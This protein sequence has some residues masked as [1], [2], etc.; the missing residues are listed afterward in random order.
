MGHMKRQRKNIRPT[1]RE[2]NGKKAATELNSK[3]TAAD[4]H[5]QMEHDDSPI[6]YLVT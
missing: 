4:M 1:K 6:N 2:E 3:E 5:P